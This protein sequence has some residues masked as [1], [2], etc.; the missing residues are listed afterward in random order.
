MWANPVSSLFSERKVLKVEQKKKQ[1][2][3]GAT[4]AMSNN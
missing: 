3:K 2:A 1:W 4:N